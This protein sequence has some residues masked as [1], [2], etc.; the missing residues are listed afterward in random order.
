[1]GVVIELKDYQFYFQEG[2]N[3][4]SLLIN[5]LNELQIKAND[6]ELPIIVHS[7]DFESIVYMKWKSNYK[8][9]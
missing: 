1:M 4:A 2:V 9:S 6:P 8:L 5:L 7:F 3:V